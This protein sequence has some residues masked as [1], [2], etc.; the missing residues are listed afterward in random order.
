MTYRILAAAIL[1]AAALMTGAPAKAAVATVD[2]RALFSDNARWQAAARAAGER[3][4]QLEREFDVKSEGL[5]GEAL[6]S[7]VQ[8]YRARARAAEKEELTAA[9]DHVTA[10]IAEVAREQ[11]YDTVVR[12]RSLLYGTADG[13]ITDAVKAR[14]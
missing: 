9:Y 5:S 4:A 2:M 1:T 7:L 11:G 13:D 10:V 3:R 8:E 6:A 12:A 14:L